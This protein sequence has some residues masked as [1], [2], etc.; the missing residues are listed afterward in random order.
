MA[1][2]L[3]VNLDKAIQCKKPFPLLLPYDCL[4]NILS[5][6]FGIQWSTLLLLSQQTTEAPITPL[7]EQPMCEAD[8]EI[9]FLRRRRAPY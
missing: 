7:A 9:S 1:F 4:Q 3:I 5:A 8:G 6:D 2:H